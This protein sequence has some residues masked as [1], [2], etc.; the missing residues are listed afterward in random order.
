[1]TMMGRYVGMERKQ[2]GE[3]FGQRVDEMHGAVLLGMVVHGGA[4]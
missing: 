2:A 3:R 4:G 1:M